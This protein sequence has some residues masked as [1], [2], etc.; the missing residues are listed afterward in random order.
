MH[1][2]KNETFHSLATEY[3]KRY[4]MITELI[5]AS[6]LG[7]LFH[8][9]H[10]KVIAR[11]QMRPGPPI[12][13]EFLHV[14][15]FAFKQTW[16]PVSASEVHYVTAVLFCIAIWSGALYVVIVGGNVL[17]L[18]GFYLLHKVL[19]HHMGLSAGS[20]YTKFGAIRSVISATSE[21]PLFTTVVVIYL[22][23]GSLHLSEIV[24]WQAENGILLISAF[25]AAIAMYLILLSKMPYGPFSIVESKELVS[26]YKTEHFGSWRATLEI[27]FAIKTVVL[28]LTFVLLFFGGHSW[29]ILLA[30]MFLLLLSLS[31]MC[32]FC[33]MLG[34]YDAVTIQSLMTGIL[35]AY[36]IGV[37]VL[38]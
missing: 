20:P 15:K 16:I 3:E 14:A 8:G 7:L 21:I 18:F 34:P 24:A 27:G 25:P 31:F 26:G 30:L 1:Q 36:I 6:F 29:S 2:K 37:W 33:P 9:I 13:Q 10:R 32:A 28:L 23:T 4:I 22:F 38:L 35:V 11:V 12:W 17:L 19:E 5:T